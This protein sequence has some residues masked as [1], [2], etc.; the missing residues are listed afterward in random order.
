MKRPQA[1]HRS[2]YEV[3]DC[4]TLAEMKRGAINGAGRQV[5]EGQSGASLLGII[6][7]EL[8]MSDFVYKRH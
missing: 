4:T 3:R 2:L 5:L 1:L 7:E 8:N 6:S